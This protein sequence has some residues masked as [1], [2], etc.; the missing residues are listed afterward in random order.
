MDRLSHKYGL[1]SSLNWQSVQFCIILLPSSPSMPRIHSVKNTLI[2][3]ACLIRYLSFSGMRCKGASVPTPAASNCHVARLIQD[4]VYDSQECIPTP[5]RSMNSRNWE[6]KSRLPCADEDLP[7][8][9]L[10]M[11]IS[12]STDTSH[13]FQLPKCHSSLH[14]IWWS[15]VFLVASVVYHCFF[16]FLHI[17][18][19]SSGRWGASLPPVHFLCFIFITSFNLHLSIRSAFRAKFCHNVTITGHFYII[20]LLFPTILARFSSEK[21]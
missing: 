1:V 12:C 7:Q 15:H 2:S 17:F 16:V 19:V 18:S 21:S 6:E 9:T 10:V 4:V 20:N 8:F 13:S 14:N 5:M 11:R 3:T